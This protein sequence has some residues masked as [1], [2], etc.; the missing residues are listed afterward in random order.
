MADVSKKSKTISVNQSRPFL[1]LRSFEENNKDAFGGRDNEIK[2]LFNLVEDHT[3]TVVFGTSGIGKTSL[4]KAGLMPRLRENFYFPIYIRIDYS[5]DES[6]VE[7]L[8]NIAF[9][10]MQILDPSIAPIENQTLWEY[11][12]DT[13]LLNG[14]VKPVLILDQFEEL[15]SLGIDK[16]K[17]GIPELVTELAD[18]AQNRI[19]AKVK[20][21]F[22]AQNKT[23]PSRYNKNTYRVVLSLRE[24]YLARLD[25]LKNYIPIIMDN[26][27]RVLQMTLSQALKA[28]IIPG[29]GLINKEVA[30]KLIKKIVSASKLKEHIRD[31]EKIKVEPFL[32]SLICDRLNEKRIENGENEITHELVEKFKVDDVSA[33]FY[34]ET[35]SKF[36][37]NVNEAIESLLLDNKGNR[38]LHALGD[39][40][41]EYHVAQ[42]ALDALIDARIIRKENR[43]DVDYLELIHDVLA[44][45][46]KKRRDRRL[47][48]E[49][50]KKKLR[51][52]LI[53]FGIVLLFIVGLAFARENLVD[54]NRNAAFKKFIAGIGILDENPTEALDSILEG[55]ADAGDRQ[56]DFRSKAFSIFEKESIYS[57]LKD[58]S[59][60]L[61][62]GNTNVVFNPNGSSYLKTVISN[63]YKPIIWKG[64]FDWL[65]EY[66][67]DA[68]ITDIA[69]SPNERYVLL[70]LENNT[71]LLYDNKTQT[72][73]TELT[74]HSDVVSSV[75]FSPD[76]EHYVTASWD[77]TAVVR[78]LK[79]GNEKTFNMHK[80]RIFSV[81]FADNE[82]LLTAGRDGLSYLWNINTSNQSAISYDSKSEIK[83]ITIS[84]NNS[85][86]AI[87]GLIEGE[88]FS[89]NFESA[90]RTKI[91]KQKNK[92]HEITSVDYLPNGKQLLASYNDSLGG[93]VI[94][95]NEQL[96]AT[97]TIPF[98]KKIMSAKF[99][100]DKKAIITLDE[101]GTL[102]KT[103]LSADR[104]ITTLYPNISSF[105]FSDES[106]ICGS[107]KYQSEAGAFN[108]DGALI[109]KFDELK[110]PSD[111]FTISN[112]GSKLM[113]SSLLEGEV[114]I[115]ESDGSEI[116]FIPHSSKITTL[117]FSPDDSMAFVGYRDGYGVLWNLETNDEV[118]YF[119]ES[120]EISAFAFSRDGVNIFIGLASGRSHFYKM[121]EIET[122]KPTL[123]NTFYSSSTITS[124]DIS[125]SHLVT[126]DE[127]GVVTVWERE[128]PLL[129]P[130]IDI[131]P[132]RTITTA[133][134]SMVNLID[135]SKATKFLNSAN[136]DNIRFTIDLGNSPKIASSIDIT[137][138]NDFS[139]R[140]PSIVE[141]KGSVEGRYYHSIS[142]D[143]IPCNDKRLNT[144]SLSFEN[145]KSYSRYRIEFSSPCRS[146]DRVGLNEK[147]EVSG[148]QLSEVQLYDKSSYSAPKKYNYYNG[149]V[150]SVLF[151][152]DEEKLLI[153]TDKR[154]RLLDLS[155][156]EVEQELKGHKSKVISTSFINKGANVITATGNGNIRSW[157]I[158]KFENP[159]TQ[160]SAGNNLKITNISFS[161]D[162]AKRDIHEQ[163]IQILDRNRMGLWT[164]EGD[165]L[166]SEVTLIDSIRPKESVKHSGMSV[167]LSNG[168]YLAVYLE[169]PGVELWEIAS[170]KLLHT[171]KDE[172][173]SSTAINVSD[174]GK[175]LVYANYDNKIELVNLETK[176]STAL[177]MNESEEN[178]VLLSIHPRDPKK[179]LGI[180]R[181]GTIRLIDMATKED[182]WTNPQNQFVS[183]GFLKFSADGN[184]ILTNAF[185]P[186]VLTIMKDSVKVV[187]IK[188]FTKDLIAA[189]FSR[190]GT[191]FLTVS[192]SL[193]SPAMLWDAETFNIIQFYKSDYPIS[194]VAFSDNGDAIVLGD[195]NGNVEVYSVPPTMKEAFR[196]YLKLKKIEDH[197]VEKSK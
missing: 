191:K 90:T 176:Q 25:E 197:L 35:L 1:G 22:K 114:V 70:A 42:E 12:H 92:S 118:T 5:S 64:P 15:F 164:Q 168:K 88:L 188:S 67:I 72:K 119:E 100:S 11:L 63:E 173:V 74:D 175:F 186:K 40:E 133:N 182:I 47:E 95:W 153:A 148:L 106:F 147:D 104:T 178:L 132:F 141:I 59:F 125:N 144:Y 17:D 160:F 77:H 28:A 39:F 30:K 155:T 134:W 124:V 31:E 50:N 120:H 115:L 156:G 4:L 126:G 7:Q 102:I 154:V 24:D 44:P 81:E 19:P 140:D 158:K 143:S 48:K 8:R 61:N 129:N 146:A 6:L 162:S 41:L 109:H 174:D 185:N 196:D 21:K 171:V 181:H 20:E 76:G 122:S 172:M 32:L 187:D 103:K 96:D 107:I 194:A 149:A 93:K 169:K 184:K 80:G 85:K 45:V 105:V 189:T 142:R 75:A 135:G 36:G 56:N 82:H 43:N 137:T 180:G 195:E 94:L 60:S 167:S 89:Y 46:I 10:E 33:S 101:E 97:D 192:N 121:G 23:V 66:T 58:N 69:I 68:K 2:E 73:P 53:T 9:K 116:S 83:T 131:T 29:K 49:A 170:R 127:N 52:I 13:K 179:I 38:K 165:L 136:Q 51:K 193:N 99:S 57:I 163:R 34:E 123:L 166:A 86:E 111:L 152:P 84:P 113:M 98:S 151:S 62:E 16:D 78:S 161:K 87:I 157:G 55:Y 128:K 130:E 54:K 37:Q 79:T 110:K 159:S 18:L 26:G 112:S 14:L 71:T 177:Q 150:S 183:G 27:F 117:A 145:E 3:L 108:S 91:F 139:R 190:D 138:A 65:S